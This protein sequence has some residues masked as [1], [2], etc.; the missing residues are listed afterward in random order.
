MTSPSV[1]PPADAASSDSAD[2][3]VSQDGPVLTVTL[4]RPEVR[5]AQLPSMWEE[6]ARIGADLPADVRVVVLTGAGSSFSAGLDRA[7]LGPATPDRPTL[8]GFADAAPEE[9]DQAVRIFQNGFAVWRDC[10]AIVVAAVRGHAIGAG[11]QLA[12]SADLIVASET[13]SF[14]MKETALGLVP[15]LTGT[16]PL[17]RALGYQRALYACLTAEAISGEEAAR[18][19]LAL[20]CVPDSELETEVAALVGELTAAL[21]GATRET[22]ALLRQV[23]LHTPAEQRVAE[24]RAQWR[25]IQELA[26]LMQGS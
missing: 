22:K 17:V 18:T 11:F 5:N 25:R 15:D 3:L 19:G 8:A 12:L 24:R 13:A 1:S 10:P 14:V 23:D 4:N 20:R 6:L 21:P 7:M 16:H 9:F 26:A 2:I